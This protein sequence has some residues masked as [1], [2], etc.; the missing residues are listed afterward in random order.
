MEALPLYLIKS[1]IWL[2]G[3][4]LVYFLFLKNERFFRLK[5][6]YLITGILISFLFPLLTFHYK[7][8]IPALVTPSGNLITQNQAQLNEFQKE[9]P[10]DSFNYKYIIA[11]LYLAGVLFFAFR[12]VK[13]IILLQ[14]I[15]R[16]EDKN[17]LGNVW[18]IRTSSFRD[19][20]SFFHYIFISPSLDETE[21]EIIMNHE[22]AHINQWHWLDLLLV[23]FIRLFQWVNPFAWVYS[24]F[25]RQNH[26]YIA[27]EVALQRT[28]DPA[29]YKAVL[30]NQLFNTRILSLSN[31]FNFSLNKKRFD[32]M[33]KAPSSP[34]RK[35]K[36]LSVLPVIA[37]VFYAFAKPEFRYVPLENN[38]LSE[39]DL[40]IPEGSPLIF[41]IKGYKN[42]NMPP[43]TAFQIIPANHG[44]V[45][46]IVRA[47]DGRPL[48]ASGVVKGSSSKE[49]TDKYGEKGAS[50][51]IEVTTR[52]KALEMNPNPPMPRLA[53]KDFPTFGGRSHLQFNDWVADQVSYPPEATANGAEG[54]VTVNFTVELNGAITN[55]RPLGSADPLLAGEIIRVIKSSPQWEPAENPE[56]K[57]PFRMSVTVGFQLPDEVVGQTPF[58]VVEEM[59]QYP[60]GEGELLKFIT[61]NTSYPEEAKAQRIEGKVIIRFIVNT[62]GNAKGA[63]VLKGVDPLLDAEAVRVISQLKGFKPGKQG[64]KAISVWYMVPVNFTLSRVSQQR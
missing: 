18:V 47:E 50:G 4:A 20:F 46:G 11:L 10:G 1:M 9:V 5:R 2:T 6:Y 45:E 31:S 25:I 15:I 40:R 22:L 35:M 49:A 51:V 12:M 30:I 13:N 62:E 27:D 38:R 48:P 32:M 58:V 42:Y 55:I 21:S 60:G 39:P 19:S 43:L 36:I 59:P 24:G 63:S 16:T 7:I 17:R 64:G 33:K 34:Y 57:E 41:S 3:F 23:E 61:E 53:P 54:Y 44:S 29:I 26:E 28:S 8:E 56:I 37:I 52:K 14:K